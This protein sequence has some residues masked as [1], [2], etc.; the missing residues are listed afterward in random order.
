MSRY[1]QAKWIGSPNFGLPQGRHG[2]LVKPEAIVY[3]IAQGTLI[4]TDAWFRNP[5]SEASAH[6]EVGKLAEVHQYVELTD[7]PWTNG[8]IQ[9][10]DLTIPWLKQCVTDGINPNTV[11]ATIEH[12]G[13]T[14][15]VWPEAQ[16]QGS[17]ALTVWL[18]DYYDL[19]GWLHDFNNR[20][21]GHYR[22]DSVDRPNCP[23]PGWPKNRLKA[24]LLAMKEDDVYTN[25]ELTDQIEAAALE[26]LLGLDNAKIGASNIKDWIRGVVKTA[27]DAHAAT[28]HGSAATHKHPLSATITGETEEA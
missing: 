13:M 22:I 6:F 25:R 24:D 15:L 19:W 27:V 23:G 10:P 26:G 20:F 9:K 5:A 4:G 16:Y 21:I 3:H 1:P 14:G 8:K 28:P 17:L 12:E 11:T 2:Q 18:L 7:A